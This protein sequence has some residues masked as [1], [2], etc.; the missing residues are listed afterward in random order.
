MVSGR[1]PLYKEPGETQVIA[2]ERKTL[3]VLAVIALPLF[4]ARGAHAQRASENAVTAA[5][6]VFGTT[7]GNESI[8]IYNNFDVRGFSPLQA[9]NVRVEGLYFDQVGDENDRIAESSRIR[10]GIAAQG[11]AFPAPTGIVDYALRIP[12]DTA[13]L[14][15]LSEANS[16]GYYTLQFDGAVP[17]GSKLSLGGGIAMNRGVF[18]GGGSNYEGDVGVLLKWRPLPH[19]EILPFWS[20]KDTY[21]QKEGEAYEPTGDFL[22]SPTP[23]RHFYG[24]KWALGRD[25]SVNYGAV[26][27]YTLPSWLARLGLFRSELASPKSSFPQLESLLP[28]G[29]GELE[30]DLNPPLHLGSTSGEFRVEKVFSLGAWA[31]RLIFSLRARN[32]NGLYGNSVTADVGPQAI[33]QQLLDAPAPN[34]QFGPPTRDHADERWLGFAYEV[35]RKDWFEISAGVQKAR[36]HKNTLTPGEPDVVL[37]T[38]P[39]L[40]TAS[41][42]GHVSKRV[43]VF[44]A[45]TQGL[46]DNGITPS[47]AVN[48]NEALPATTSRQSEGGVRWTI[49]PRLNL[50]AG[51]FDLKKPYFNLDPANVYRDLGQLENKGV[52]LSLSGNLFEQLDIVA[53]GVLSQPKVSGDAVRLGVTGDRPVGLYSRKFVLGANWAP[54]AARGMSFDV[55]ANYFGSIP[56]TLDDAVSRPAYMTFNWD[57]RYPFKMAG[58]NASLKFAVNNLANVRELAV[59]DAGT[60]GI[61]FGS[62]RRFD[63]RLIV[64]VS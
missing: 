18:P 12:G 6:D 53:G 30:V 62:G 56:G 5:E 22:P 21:E 8:G 13:S 54:P 49:L 47:N 19:L 48:S 34:V 26:V 64:D 3:A 24:P 25:F 9:G 14:S 63:L 37:D 40:L 7:V 52:E 55:A 35:A 50:V 36:Y 17:L 28:N 45:F 42:T 10:V 23:P 20:R 29:H 38:S 27:N 59:F 1:R 15:A 4:A 58:E 41:A 33:G 39:W 57:T 11:Y 46:E 16:F 31:Q 60:Y 44:A 51:V 61:F 32:W 43:A 2:V